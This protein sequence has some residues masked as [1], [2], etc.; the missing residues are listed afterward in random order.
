[1][2]I[3]RKSPKPGRAA[4]TVAFRFV[5]MVGLLGRQLDMRPRL[6]SQLL[7]FIHNAVGNQQGIS[8]ERHRKIQAFSKDTLML[9]ENRL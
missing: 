5:M 9:V 4:S 6:L 7:G 3:W 1:M 2:E 8:K